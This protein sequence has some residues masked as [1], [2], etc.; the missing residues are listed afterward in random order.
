MANVIY[1]Y[2]LID[3][4]TAEVRYIGKSIRPKERLTNHMNDVSNCHRSH[5]LQSLKSKGLKP[6]MVILEEM[7]GESDWQ[8]SERKWIQYGRDANWPLTNNTDGGDGVCGLPLETRKK[9]ALTW[10]GRKHKPETIIK[11]CAARKL[12]TTSEETKNKM[13]AAQK[14]RKIEWKD[15]IGIANMK[16]TDADQ[17]VIRQRVSRGDKVID[18]AKDYGVH[19]GTITKVKMGKYPK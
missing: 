3:P 12:R 11:L 19:R 2:G 16:I 9:M 18:I 15:K 5:W 8:S 4:N 10:T 6:E 14:G 13:S 1:I 17:V 7:D